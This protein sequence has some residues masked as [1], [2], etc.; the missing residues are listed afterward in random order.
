MSHTCPLCGQVGFSEPQLFEH[1]TKKYS[2]TGMHPECVSGGVGQERGCSHDV[3]VLQGH[4]CNMQTL[5]TQLCKGLCSVNSKKLQVT[6]LDVCHVHY[7]FPPAPPDQICPVCA[8][9]PVGEPNLVTDDLP[10]HF[11]LEHRSTA[12]EGEWISS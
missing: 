4:C 7:P 9:S 1:V 10:S 5:L 6:V 11:A 2:D 8:A 12:R 3:A